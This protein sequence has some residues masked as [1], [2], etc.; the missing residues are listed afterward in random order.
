MNEY[1]NLL[2]C[3]HKLEHFSP[4]AIP[5]GKDI[6]IL[7]EHEPWKI[8]LKSNNPE[9]TIEYTIYLGVFDSNEVNK[10]VKDYFKDTSKDES[11]RSSKICFASLNLD[12]EGK[13]INDSFGISTLP[14]ALSQLEKDKIKT[15]NWSEVF[16]NIKEELISKIGL[17]FK[18]TITNSENEVIEVCTITNMNQLL[19]FQEK[20]ESI[21]DWSIKPNKSIYF[22]FF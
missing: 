11:F 4:A 1:K 12:I 21:I 7:D 6:D 16:E 9:K 20:I 8:P 2:S 14:W 15:D 5:K 13:Y 18:E 22:I 19:R 17:I 3:W 10:F